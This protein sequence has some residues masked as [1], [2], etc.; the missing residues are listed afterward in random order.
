M[1]S[2]PLVTKILE[3]IE[4]LE[5]LRDSWSFLWTKSPTASTTL[6]FAW[7]EAWWRTYRDSFNGARLQVITFWRG[8]RLVGAAP[9]YVCWIGAP[10]FQM[11]RLS[12]MSTGEAEHEETCGEYLNLLHF[13][14]ESS[15]CAEAFW[16]TVATI[17]WDQFRF[18]DVPADAPL[19]HA[20]S[21]WRQTRVLSRGFCPMADLSGGFDHYLGRLSATSRQQA[22]RLLREAE[23]AGARLELVSVDR[24]MEVFDE[25][26]R[27]HQERWAAEAKPGVFASLRFSTFHRSLVSAW[28]PEG[29]AVIARLV[30][31]TNTAAVLY[32]FILNRKFDFYQSGIRLSDPGP[33][34]SPGNLA[35]LM[36]MRALIER[37]VV[38]YDFLRGSSLY[39]ERLSTGRNSLIEMDA[40]R[41]TPRAAL[42]RA[43]H[44]ARRI[45]LGAIRFARRRRA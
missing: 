39:K 28:L 37:G 25:M 32:G 8:E 7:L 29:R 21:L 43:A 40:W 20:H 2:Y 13:P 4:E 33:L 6:H 5:T 15:A 11:R 12:F 26:A 45:G 35:H 9:L 23:K 44:L 19:V 34:R 17:P 31:G 18:L 22:R 27:L 36:L 38:T 3:S 14:E 24:S 41:N 1:R 16:Q 42:H 30:V 10:P